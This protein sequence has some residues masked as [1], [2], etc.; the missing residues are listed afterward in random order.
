MSGLPC[1]LLCSITVSSWGL[2]LLYFDWMTHLGF[3]KF[4]P[5]VKEL[6]HPMILSICTIPWGSELRG[7]KG[8]SASP[9]VISKKTHASPQ[10]P[11][12]SL[13]PP[14]KTLTFH[15]IPAQAQDTREAESRC[16]WVGG[17][18]RDKAAGMERK[19]E[20]SGK[21]LPRLLGQWQLH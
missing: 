17:S 3:G 19:D 1:F 2:L 18:L 21:V 4:V 7:G 16:S 15:T 12:P 5:A 11:A 13:Q 6:V 20:R 14:Y 10:P 9:A 8:D